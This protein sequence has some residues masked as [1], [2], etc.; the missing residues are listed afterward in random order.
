M[1]DEQL[2]QLPPE[3]NELM[4]SGP[5]VLSNKFYVAL[6]PVGARI[7]FAEQS[8]ETSPK[9][10]TAVVLPFQDAIELYKLLSKMLKPIEEA[11]AGATPK[12]EANG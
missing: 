12:G 6:G 2:P 5:A 9:F 1:T 7:T 4:F 3:E 11:L 10:R 8:P